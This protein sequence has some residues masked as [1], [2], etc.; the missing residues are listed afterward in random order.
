MLWTTL[1]S[2]AVAA[3]QVVPVQGAMSAADGTPL[4]GTHVITV[5][6]W[7]GAPGSLDPVAS[8][9]GPVEF[10]N[11]AFT[12]LIPVDDSLAADGPVAEWITV[13]LA[14][15]ESGPV[16]VAYAPNALYARS[17]D[18]ISGQSL[19]DLDQ[20]YARVD[21]S[22]GM[23]IGSV[24]VTDLTPDAPGTLVPRSFL[25]TT[26]AAYLPLTGGTL[27]G[28]LVLS[29]DPTAPNQAA[30]KAYVDAALTPYL[31]AATATATYLAKGGGTMTG[32]LTLAG[33]PTGANDAATKAY[34]D[35]A[36][37]AA[38]SAAS[39]TYLPLS[40][41]TITG[42]LTVNGALTLAGAPT[43]ANH[44][45]TKAYVD[46]NTSQG[47]AAAVGS[48]PEIFTYFGDD[49]CP[50]D[51]TLI[52]SGVAFAG[53]YTHV[54]GSTDWSCVA[55]NDATAPGIANGNTAWV[56]PASIE[57]AGY[58]PSG[59]PNYRRLKCSV[60]QVNTGPCFTYWGNDE[61]PSSYPRKLWG[62][63]A[64]SAYYT[65]TARKRECLDV[66]NVDTELL[67]GQG[68]QHGAIAYIEYLTFQS[69]VIPGYTESKALQC[70]QCCKGPA[71]SIP[72]AQSCAALNV[73]NP[74]LPNGV[75][76]IDPNGGS[77]SDKFQA[78]CDMSTDGG[79]WTLAIA[80]INGSA[81]PAGTGAVTRSN[82]LFRYPTAPGKLSDADINLVA[83]QDE[84]R[85]E[86]G[87]PG[88][89]R[90]FKLTHDYANTTGQV[91]SPDQCRTSQSSAWVTVTGGGSSSHVGLAST[92]NG[93]GCG[94]CADRCGGGNGTGFWHSWN[95][96]YGG[97]SSNGAYTAASVYV[98]GYM[99]AR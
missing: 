75:Y 40:G 73:S 90:F 58:Y 27:T 3:P 47:G 13:S 57:G 62:G 49:V 61:C 44:A 34:V 46:A 18:A 16:Q 69:N 82:L 95:A 5:S 10:E 28:A 12:H 92:P 48:T 80:I 93:D 41:G 83:T 50:A 8:T 17:A 53:Y 87:T 85:Y 42:A 26:I 72:T 99:W 59:T 19:D 77:D 76:W 38:G 23:T 74:G 63:Y 94:T 65:H 37:A 97:T 56:Y 14:G 64:I 81:S 70:A 71:L 86:V 30:N 1:F 55:P 98:N 78:Y 35:G 79:G 6:L 9:T 45:A 15:A 11:G 25:E 52:Y 96:Y 20:R 32:P 89:K 33:A 2:L 51:T 66:Q 68:A 29:G 88:Y 21:G 36:I 91:Y 22:A 24:T 54:G 67:N 39:G 43:G 84:Y 60:C 31:S 7:R 4:S